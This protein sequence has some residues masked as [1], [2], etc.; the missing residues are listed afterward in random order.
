VDPFSRQR[1]TSPSLFT[2]RRT[3]ASA[4]QNEPR[5]I[6][7]PHAGFAIAAFVDDPSG[8]G[9]VATSTISGAEDGVVGPGAA[10]GLISGADAQA[11]DASTNRPKR[12]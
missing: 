9:A 11:I 8:G 2:A 5:I 6:T 7:P 1:R 10:A 4:S 12:A 3:S